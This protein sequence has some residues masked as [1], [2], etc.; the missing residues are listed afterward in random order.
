MGRHAALVEGTAASD[1]DP[2]TEPIVTRPPF[3]ADPVRVGPPAARPPRRSWSAA[4]SVAVM[5]AAHLVCSCVSL[6]VAY[7]W[8]L[9]GL[10]VVSATVLA[11][12]YCRSL[13]ARLLGASCGAVAVFAVAFSAGL[14]AWRGALGFHVASAVSVGTVL[15]YVGSVAVALGVC[16]VVDVSTR[17][18]LRAW[19]SGRSSLGR[20]GVVLVALLALTAFAPISRAVEG[21]GFGV[22]TDATGRPVLSGVAVGTAAGPATTALGCAVAAGSASTPSDGPGAQA[23]CT[24]HALIQR[25]CHLDTDTMDA[26]QGTPSGIAL[27]MDPAASNMVKFSS[28][29]TTSVPFTQAGI[30]CV[31][32]QVSKDGT[33]T[34]LAHSLTLSASDWNALRHVG[35]LP[36]VL[37]NKLATA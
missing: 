13:D 34:A 2:V 28:R 1:R 30:E 35:A 21:G 9:Y 29:F 11:L 33:T 7:P 31:E 24:R 23:E 6:F 32:H 20:E 22:V 25:V 18:T 36:P 37:E 4:G 26:Q 5:L 27:W 3:R 14:D 8:W 12:L 16:A 15:A 19:L 10:A 17:R